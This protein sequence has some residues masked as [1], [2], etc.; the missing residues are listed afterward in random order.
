M[1]KWIWILVITGW[2][3]VEVKAST[4]I[5]YLETGLQKAYGIFVSLGATSLEPN[6]VQFAIFDK[7]PLPALRY[8]L[9]ENKIKYRKWLSEGKCREDTLLKWGALWDGCFAKVK[10]TDIDLLIGETKKG[11]MNGFGETSYG[12]P[13][14]GAKKWIVTK[15]RTTT[16]GITFVWYILVELKEGKTANVLLT[17]ENVFDIEKEMKDAL[18]K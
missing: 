7:D 2:I 5:E 14:P 16:E 3:T 4:E 13:K 11:G 6:V 10:G 9:K 1:K 15:M 17:S 12:V 18:C 8:K